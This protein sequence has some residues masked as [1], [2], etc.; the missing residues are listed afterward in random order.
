MTLLDKPNAIRGAGTW[1]ANVSHFHDKECRDI[2]DSY[3]KSA[4]QDPGIPDI[5]DKWNHMKS[6]VKRLLITYSSCKK[7]QSK[8]EIQSIQDFINYE[9]SK[10]LPSINAQSIVIA[11]ERNAQLEQNSQN[12]SIFRSQEYTIIGGREHTIIGGRSQLDIFLQ[13]SIHAKS[14][15]LSPNYD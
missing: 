6:Q 15:P 4:I 9:N 8:N 13:R 1:K 12:G 11:K 5:Q 2:L 14:T 7:E 10:P 3:L